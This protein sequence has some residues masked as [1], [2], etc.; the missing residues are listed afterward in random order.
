MESKRV[1]FVAH[2]VYIHLGY[3]DVPIKCIKMNFYLIHIN[4]NLCIIFQP[5]LRLMR[6]FGVGIRDAILSKI[7]ELWCGYFFNV[8]GGRLG[9][10]FLDRRY[11]VSVQGV[12]EV[13][14]LHAM[15]G[16]R[17]EVWHVW[18][19]CM[20]MEKWKLVTKLH[21]GI[22]MKALPQWNCNES[23]AYIWT[24]IY[25]YIYI[26]TYTHTYIYIEL[27]LY[28]RYHIIDKCPD[29]SV[30]GIS[31]TSSLDDQKMAVFQESSW[32]GTCSC[33]LNSHCSMD[34]V[35]G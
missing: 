25:I 32:S 30:L 35:Q 8:L 7:V 26:N 21:S 17:G 9:T 33:R 15:V 20:E 11:D 22:A 13:V 29:F 31:E 24:Y 2:M 6:L 4:T 16:W 18:G 10:P 28:I 1:F 12:M 23:S 3:S 34:E 27:S 5:M 19:A 14:V